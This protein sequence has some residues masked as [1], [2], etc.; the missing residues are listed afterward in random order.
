MPAMSGDVD[1]GGRVGVRHFRRRPDWR[2]DGNSRAAAAS[3]ELFEKLA[4]LERHSARQGRVQLLLKHNPERKVL[5]TVQVERNGFVHALLS[6][7]PLEAVGY[8]YLGERVY[9]EFIAP[10]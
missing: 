7:T 10:K 4:G 9:G 2:A 8:T 3:G 1:E 6:G 5:H